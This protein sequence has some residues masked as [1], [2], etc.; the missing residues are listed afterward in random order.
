LQSTLADESSLRSRRDDDAQQ[1]PLTAMA[2]PL[3]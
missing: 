1:Q 3:T 2:L